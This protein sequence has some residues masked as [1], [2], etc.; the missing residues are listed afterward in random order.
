MWFLRARCGRPLQALESKPHESS[1]RPLDK[2]GTCEQIPPN[3][4]IADST[5]ECFQ[6][7]RCVASALRR[8]RQ[9]AVCALACSQSLDLS[10][11]RTWHSIESELK[12]ATMHCG[13]CREDIAPILETCC[14][15]K[16]G[17]EELERT[18]W[19]TSPRLDAVPVK[20][21][22]FLHKAISS[23]FLHG[24]HAGQPIQQ[25]VKDLR[26][27]R[28]RP[29]ELDIELVFWHGRY[30]TLCHRRVWALKQWVSEAEASS[31]GDSARGDFQT[32]IIAWVLPLVVDS[33]DSNG[34]SVVHRF[35]CG[36]DSA[37]DGVT[38]DVRRGKVNVHRISKSRS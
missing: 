12:D 35:L 16:I 25:L 21:I 8:L 18:V 26:A 10:Q 7:M 15:E 23:Y 32:N 20:E 24:P 31:K 34:R 27:G 30:R 38:V 1:G 37:N 11:Q 9:L 5:A 29:S 28:T 14:A 3:A 13:L 17:F 4:G 22:R 6:T 19:L 36:C 2:I 33:T